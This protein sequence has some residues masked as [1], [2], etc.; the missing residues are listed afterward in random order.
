LNK[1]ILMA[2]MG[3]DIG[4][5][6]THIVEL[7][8][9][10]RRRGWEVAVASNGGAYAG[11]LEEA[12]ARHYSVP[13]NRRGLWPVVKSIFLMWRAVRRFKPGIVHAHARIP[14]FICGLLRRVRR[15]AF[16]TTAHYTFDTDGS[17]RFLSNWGDKTI[18][19]SDDIREYLM[20]EYAVAERDIFMTI[21]GIDTAKFSPGA[22]ADGIREELGI[23]AAE[24]VVCHISRLDGE[25]AGDP[26]VIARQLIEAAG[27][28][29]REAPDV[30]VL[31]VGGGDMYGELL[32]RARE[33][34]GSVG[35]DAVIMTGPR[36]DVER[37]L[38][39]SDVFVGVSRAALEAL[40]TGLPV[41]L[42]GPQGYMGA[43]TEE[44]YA[45][46]AL[47]NFC[48]RGC[49]ASE[50]GT[51]RGEITKTLGALRGGAH[52]GAAGR[53]LV[54]RDYSLGRMADDCVR[55]YEAALRRPRRVVM[56]GYY[57]FGNAGDEAILHAVRAGITGAHDD[58]SITVLS[59]DPAQ[60]R[61]RH[62]C[63]AVRRFGVFGVLRALSRCDA[64]V[65]GGGSLLQDQTS[66][67][68]LLYY[69]WIIALARK[70]GKKVMIY[71]NGIG[72]VTRESNR[73]RVKKVV[74]GADV[75][76]LRD[77]GSKDELLAM[78]VIRG[79]IR[80]TADPVF[81]IG[82]APR[83]RSKEILGARGIPA[84]RPF[85]VVCV[86]RWTNGGGLYGELAKM[87]DGIYDRYAMGV[88]FVAM[89]TPG[90]VGISLEISRMMKCPSY[91]LD[92]QF[93]PS[94]LIGIMGA[95]E[96]VVA[97]RLHA[98]IFAARAAVPSV[99][100]MC[101]PK[102]E[103]LARELEMPSAG[104]VESFGAERALGAVGEITAR[105]AEYS[106][107]LRERAAHLERA[108]R[109]DPEY[110]FDLLERL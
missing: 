30:R 54:E 28:I 48:C 22:V 62:N 108:A 61:T 41:I 92:G 39:A 72:P 109:R 34:N 95:S 65:S 97:M 32:V 11:R 90:D 1:R 50:T 10:L 94:E 56:S 18:A 75:V 98:L 103:A 100:I 5:A 13:M 70:L 51:L 25:R 15:F 68:S 21:N 59:K 80:V 93:T 12:G 83:E 89:Q 57:G 82:A 79:D 86:R 40:S 106:A 66:T 46:A 37:I 85:A 33:A 47:T 8:L 64:L 99:G 102:L 74:M 63:G 23:G 6:E 19:V 105:R 71:A 110:L 29:A 3:L 76:T 20:R 45:A 69:L 87:C 14:A 2:T 104:S 84:D 53:E 35:R 58:I 27:S 78:G 16:V 38:A 55:A 91:V 43:L 77:S 67:R 42:A 7:A 101:D 44:N 17:L 96:L 9:E 107:K 60:T 31:I 4:G 81:T 49:G 73:R 24:R 88:V 26:A 36:T 52:A